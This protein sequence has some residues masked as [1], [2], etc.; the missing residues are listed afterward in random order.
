VVLI[1]STAQWPH[2]QVW[3]AEAAKITTLLLSPMT[4]TFSGDLRVLSRL[5]EKGTRRTRARAWR[6]DGQVRRRRRGRRDPQG[7]R[8]EAK[9][10]DI[11]KETQAVDRDSISGLLAR[12]MASAAAPR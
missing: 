8:W 2:R 11:V 10:D 7:P 6:R 9:L 1:G 3:A 12:I 4:E 5:I